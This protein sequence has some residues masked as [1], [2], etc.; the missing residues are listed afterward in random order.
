MRPLFCILNCL[1]FISCTTQDESRI[2][3]YILTEKD[4]IPEGVAF[5]EATQTIYISSTYKRKIISI[6]QRVM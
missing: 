5:D 2:K 4:L 1:V 6:D 3:D